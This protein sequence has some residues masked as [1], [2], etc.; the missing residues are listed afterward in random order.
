MS[1]GMRSDC[2]AHYRMRAQT[3]A[4]FSNGKKRGTCSKFKMIKMA[5]EKQKYT[6][7][8]NEWDFIYPHNRIMA[9]PKPTVSKPHKDSTALYTDLSYRI[10][11]KSVKK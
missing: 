11:P 10:S 1:Y 2:C 5:K 7:H 6:Q 4:S 3:V 9:F 8:T